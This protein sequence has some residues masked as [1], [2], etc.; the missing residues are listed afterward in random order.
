MSTS[1]KPLLLLLTAALVASFAVPAGA[2]TLTINPALSYLRLQIFLLNPDTMEELQI[3]F[4]QA[5]GSDYGFASGTLEVT[6]SGTDITFDGGSV[7]DFIPYDNGNTNLLPDVGGGMPGDPGTGAPADFG[8]FIDLQ[9]LEFGNGAVR[10]VV[11]DLTGGPEP[12]VGTSF[13]ASNLTLAIASG[14]LDANLSGF[15]EVV[16]SVDISNNSSLNL[17]G[18]SG[19]TTI[20]NGMRYVKVPIALDLT[21]VV[22]VVPGLE[23]TLLGRMTGQ[24]V[25]IPEPSS[26]VLLGMATLAAPSLCYRR[27]RR[28]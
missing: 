22:E 9:G 16:E 19:F 18:G 13:N 28:S 26:M 21:I 1:S 14:A 4:A 25:T 6:V 23:L 12:I 24:I 3:S 15:A 7:L 8:L 10:D 5:P 2:E 20:V 17:L 11:G 27:F